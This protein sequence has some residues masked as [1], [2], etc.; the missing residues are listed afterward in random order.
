M[1]AFE[2]DTTIEVPIIP[3]LNVKGYIKIIIIVN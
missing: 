2:N 3:I 1:N